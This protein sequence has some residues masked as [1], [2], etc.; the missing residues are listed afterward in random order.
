MRVKAARI[1]GGKDPA[2]LISGSADGAKEFAA[3]IK[4]AKPVVEFFLGVL[5]ERERD[6]HRLIGLAERVVLPLIRAIKSPMERE[7]FV[8]SAARSLGLSPE[9]VRESLGRIPQGP[10]ADSAPTPKTPQTAVTARQR[11]EHRLLAIVHA[12]PETAL[13]KRVESEYSRITGV[14]SLSS[15]ALPESLAFQV[16]RELGEEPSEDAAD[17]LLNAF[18]SAVLREAYQETVGE[19][20]RAEAAGD[21]TGVD[22]AQKKCSEL[23]ARLAAF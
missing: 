14:H 21:T 23:S 17:E 4:D 7:H 12:Y 13:A 9:A 15:E 3:C 11:Q 10:V 2:D 18:E 8:Q 19:L 16:E 5:A 20:R 1:S 6:P 22:A